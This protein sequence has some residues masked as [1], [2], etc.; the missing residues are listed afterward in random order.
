M[1]LLVRILFTCV[2][3]RTA[4]SQ[5]AAEPGAC[6]GQS[7]ISRALRIHISF[8]PFSRPLFPLM[9]FV[10]KKILKLYSCCRVHNRGFQCVFYQLM[11]RKVTTVSKWKSAKFVG[12]KE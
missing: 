5:L 8:Q 4:V 10:V 7:G 3:L 6:G 9:I 11:E 2:L 12:V 1:K